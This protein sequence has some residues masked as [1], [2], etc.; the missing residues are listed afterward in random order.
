MAKAEALREE[1][2]KKAA[3]RGDKE[4]QESDNDE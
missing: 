3:E 4:D 2:A 1:K